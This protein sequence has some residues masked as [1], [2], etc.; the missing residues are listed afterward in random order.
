LEA[1]ILSLEA[2]PVLST[3]QKC[4]LLPFMNKCCC[5]FVDSVIPNQATFIHAHSDD[6]LGNFAPEYLP[7]RSEEGTQGGEAALNLYQGQVRTGNGSKW[8]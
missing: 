7:Q 6:C 4:R 5:R 1:D 3:S 2:Y 8:L